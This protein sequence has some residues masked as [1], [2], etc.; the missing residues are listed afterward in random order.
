MIDIIGKR[1]Y[2]FLFSL[3]IIIPG[4]I[5]IAIWGIPLSVDFKGGTQL[6]IKFNSGTAPDT[7]KVVQLLEKLGVSDPQAITGGKDTIIIRS[8]AMDDAVRATVIKA[9]EDEFKDTITVNR[10]D[11]VGPSVSEQVAQRAIYA[12]LL[13]SVAVVIFITFSFRGVPNALRYGIC[14]VIGLIHDVL[15][16]LS[17][18]ALGGHFFGWQVDTLFFTAL[19]TVI[20]FSA[21]DTIVVFD[22]QRENTAIYRR[23]DFEKLTNHS[24]VQSL[25]RSINTQL[26]TVDFLLLSLALF[27]G[28]TLQ[29]FS[30]TLLIGMISGTYSS[31]FIAAPALVVWEKKEWKTWFRRDKSAVTA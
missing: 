17:I 12:I 30:I 19:L 20:A 29:A 4:I 23:L 10:F 24:V 7:V 9:M 15:I 27:G 31:G 18:V 13:S 2:Y 14:T 22:R 26:M 6:D 25:T 5:M 1:Y 11:T 28:A 8:A 16:I 21:Q 3:A